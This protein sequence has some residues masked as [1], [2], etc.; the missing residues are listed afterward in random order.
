M[1]T[2]LP[3]A[4]PWAARSG[5]VE[6]NQRV[7]F[8][9][10]TSSRTLSFTIR[11]PAHRMR[12]TGRYRT[13]VG[14]IDDE[15]NRGFDVEPAEVDP[16][17][18]PP[19]IFVAPISPASHRPRNYLGMWNGCCGAKTPP[20]NYDRQLPTS[21]CR[22]PWTCLARSLCCFALQPRMH[23]AENSMTP[24][25]GTLYCLSPRLCDLCVE[26]GFARGFN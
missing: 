15:A 1:R 17:P 5:A 20:A 21:P 26:R 3:P 23:I 8:G 2:P 4:Q 14:L 22:P 9:P 16:A 6:N 10:S 24:P 18:P 19:F 11:T 13:C 12:L 25:T 7:K